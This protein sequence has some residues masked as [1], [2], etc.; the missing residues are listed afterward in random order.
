MLKTQKDINNLHSLGFTPVEDYYY[1]SSRHSIVMKK[2]NTCVIVDYDLCANDN[3]AVFDYSKYC[4]MQNALMA[5]SGRLFR[6]YASEEEDL[7]ETINNW[8]TMQPDDIEITDKG[9][10]FDKV[11]V[12]N[13]PLEKTFEDLFVETYGN[14]SLGFLQKEYSLSLRNGRNAFVDYVVETGTGSYA[15]EENGVHYHHPQLIGLNAYKRQLEKQNT[16]SLMGFK[17]FRFSFENLRFKDQAIDSIRTYLGP[18]NAFRNAHFIRGTRPFA[19][20]THQKTFLQEMRDA[21]KRGVNTSLVVEPTGT[22]V[23]SDRHQW[24]RFADDYKEYLHQFGAVSCGGHEL[25]GFSEDAN[26]DVVKVTGKNLESNPNV[27]MPLYVIEET[28]IDGIV[29]WQSQSGE[30]FKAEYKD[31]PVKIFESFTEYVSTF[32]NKE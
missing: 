32:E 16:L 9:G 15:I 20:Y 10:I 22:G 25:T 2:D 27:K 29:I 31:T 12:D 30:V 26:L 24:L 14:D 7:C 5:S 6:F 4:E 13:T 8:L 17:T 11:H 28:H 21:R 19:L 18:K 23:H 3:D 1:D